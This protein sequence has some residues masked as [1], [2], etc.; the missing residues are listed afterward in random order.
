MSIY[1]LKT[2]TPHFGKHPHGPV[3]CPQGA[4]KDLR[5]LAWTLLFLLFVSAAPTQAGNHQRPSPVV[6]PDAVLSASTVWSVDRARPGDRIGLAVVMQIAR[7]FHINANRAQLSP[8]PLFS[9]YPTRLRILEITP[10]IVVPSPQF[11]QAHAIKVGFAEEPLAV[12]DGKTVVYLPLVLPSDYAADVLRISLTLSYQACDAKACLMPQTVKLTA[13][14]PTAAG[15]PAPRPAAPDLFRK[16]S[17]AEDTP[18]HDLSFSLLG[19]DITLGSPSTP[20]FWLLLLMAALGG[21]LLNLTPCVLPLI[22]IKIMSLANAAQN[23]FRCLALGWVTALGVLTFWMLLGLA[24]AVFSSVT[25]TSQLFQY[26]LFTILIGIIMAVMAFGMSGSFS[27]PLP[28]FM[29]RFQP[30]QGTLV[31]AFGIGLLSAILSTP[32]TAPVMGA[33]AAWAVAQSPGLA[34]TVFAAIGMGMALPYLVLSAAP[35]LVKRMPRSGPTGNLI[36]QTMGLFMLAAAVYFLGSGLSALAVTAPDPPSRIY[37]WGVMGCT[38]AAGLWLAYRTLGIT[39]R[40]SVRSICLVLGLLVFSASIYGGLR[41]TDRGPVDWV[42]YTED[43]YQS[44]LEEGQA[45]VMVFTAAWCLNCKALEQSVFRGKAVVERLQQN[46]VV[47]IKVDITGNNPA[48]KERLRQTGYL[49]I[50]LL[51]VYSPDGRETWKR[52]FYTAAEVLRA[53]DKATAGR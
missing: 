53:I 50:P 17:L 35:G 11:P 40:K 47:P 3:R 12:F 38:A 15:G 25:A 26:P 41:F 5:N 1:T 44:A 7:G 24:I 48:G 29:Y 19:W 6:S 31:G 27:L 34:M 43:R 18:Q 8:D 51:V 45:V 30:D 33:A 37:W 4:C 16:M 23:R 42:Y 32:C 52:S 13:E 49:T 36:K 9:P 39:K 20:G 21:L 14:L 22:P 46:D 2:E 10:P 28:Q